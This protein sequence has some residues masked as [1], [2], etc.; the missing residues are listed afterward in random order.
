MAAF[1]TQTYINNDLS[2]SSTDTY[3]TPIRTSNTVTSY[4]RDHWNGAVTYNDHDRDSPYPIK[5]SKQLKFCEN[6]NENFTERPEKVEL[7]TF[8]Y[9]QPKRELIHKNTKRWTRA[10]PV[11]N[12]FFLSYTCLLFVPKI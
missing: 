3:V 2:Y 9:V 8:D 6:I 5:S 4:S 7:L 1:Y 12:F 11:A 10:P